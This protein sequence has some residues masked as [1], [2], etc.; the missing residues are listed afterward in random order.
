MP[1][2][3]C[4]SCRRNRVKLPPQQ[5]LAHTV[6][7]DIIVLN[8][9]AKQRDLQAA[10]SVIP[11][12]QSDSIPGLFLL[13]SGLGE[14]PRI[15]EGSHKLPMEDDYHRDLLE[16]AIANS[17][18]QLATGA[19]DTSNSSA[20]SEVEESEGELKLS[21]EDREKF[22]QR[23]DDL[24]SDEEFK[25]RNTG[26]HALGHVE[27]S[28][29]AE[30]PDLSIPS[31][32]IIEYLGDIVSISDRTVVIRANVQDNY[33]VLDEK[34]LLLLE[35]RALF[36]YVSET[37]G[38]V[39]QPMYSVKFKSK[40]DA[41]TRGARVGEK[42]YFVESYANLVLT[43]RL[44]GLKGSDASN[45]NDEEI[46]ENEQDFSDDE[47][48]AE[49]KRRL[50]KEKEDRKRRRDNPNKPGAQQFRVQNG[51]EPYQTLTRPVNL[52][53]KTPLANS[54]ASSPHYQRQP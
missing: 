29:L 25:N 12:M 32:V 10:S 30:L 20:D 1:I 22:L 4:C 48:E 27:S 33:Y 2:S 45:W 23:A 44:R 7:I 53:Q 5:L 52:H 3:C 8:A 19:T 51:A 13:D 31:D 26:R 42:V 24:G 21:R 6:D 14:S 46:D 18:L 36:G 43:Q 9:N 49:Y 40:E 50:K 39:Q 35:D 54:I 11:V 34:S 28:E 17:G 47:A 16:K 15:T 38:R 41:E 37:F